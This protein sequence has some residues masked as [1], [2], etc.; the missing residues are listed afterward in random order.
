MNNE[1]IWKKLVEKGKEFGFELKES[2]HKDIVIFQRP[3][4]DT[5]SAGFWLADNEWRGGVYDR[6]NDNFY[7]FS[8]FEASWFADIL[9]YLNSYEVE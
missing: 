1:R 8:R 9:T 3:D 5:I 2:K 6:T 4:P 7:Y